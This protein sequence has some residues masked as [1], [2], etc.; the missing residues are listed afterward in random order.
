MPDYKITVDFDLYSFSSPKH[1]ISHLIHTHG[2]P[3][4]YVEIGLLEGGTLFWLSD[5]MKELH[6]STKLYGIDP[7]IGSD[8]ISQ[9]NFEPHKEHFDY[10]LSIHD[11]PNLEYI[12]KKSE[13]G[14]IDLI[15]RGV[16]AD[17]IYIDG[18]HKSSTVLTDLTLSFKLLSVGG[19]ILCDDT[20]LWKYTDKNGKS[21]VQ[22]SP[23][24][25]VE[26]FIAC[27]WQNITPVR[28]P[29]TSQTA[30]RKIC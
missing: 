25:A 9:E 12:Q 5:I 28:I 14:L 6:P 30:F 7:H 22:E 15:N 21:A 20:L 1:T 26:S 16:V 18:D 23:R 2:A 27:N 24:L 17:L 13:D 10:N 3:R 4:A 8:D 11:N 29:N 19:I